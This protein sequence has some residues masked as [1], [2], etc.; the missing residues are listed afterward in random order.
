MDAVFSHMEK[1]IFQKGPQEQTEKAPEDDTN[2][3]LLE[4]VE[5]STCLFVR[6]T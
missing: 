4:N 1:S 2:I 5:L 3:A 6:I